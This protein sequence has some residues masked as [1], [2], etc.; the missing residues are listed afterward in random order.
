MNRRGHLGTV[1]LVFGALILV[2]YAL[3]TMLSFEGNT[4]EK[5]NELNI[6]SEMIKIN[7][8][9]AM[10]NINESV[11]DSIRLSKNS[12]NFKDSFDKN[13]KKSASSKRDSTQNT[14]LYAKIDLGEYSLYFD[15]TNYVLTIENIFEDTTIKFNEAKYNYSLI[16]LFNKEGI[17]SVKTF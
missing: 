4:R 10:M 1:L 12:D 7:H 6:F 8:E 13:L 2:G 17:I 11:M 9:L 15:G 16:I 5:N 14:N 3:F